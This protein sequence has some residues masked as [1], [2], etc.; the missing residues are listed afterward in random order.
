MPCMTHI[1]LIRSFLY[2]DNAVY[3]IDMALYNI[4]NINNIVT[5]MNDA[6]VRV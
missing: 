2:I 6:Y 4:D 3:S 5:A 1:L